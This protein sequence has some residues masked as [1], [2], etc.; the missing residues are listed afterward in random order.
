MTA[1]PRTS[2]VFPCIAGLVRVCDIQYIVNPAHASQSIALLCA[3]VSLT[4]VGV[5]PVISVATMSSLFPA[6]LAHPN[7]IAIVVLMAWS[8]ALGTSPF[9]G[10]TLALQGRFGIPATCFLT[11]NFRSM[12]VAL[13][14]GSMLLAT[15]DYL[16]VG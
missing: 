15:L 2:S 7:L 12:L 6:Q 10:T 1:T 14:G 9:S 3:L 4:L 16:G 11:W 5:H 8:V 13:A